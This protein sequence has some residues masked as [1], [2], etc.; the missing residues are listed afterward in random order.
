MG[1][2]RSHIHFFDPVM[3]RRIF[4]EEVMFEEL[5]ETHRGIVSF[6]GSLF[7]R[8]CNLPVVSLSR[9]SEPLP[10]ESLEQRRARIRTTVAAMFAQPHP[11]D[12]RFRLW[13]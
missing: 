11:E 7:D 2:C 9:R 3:A 1:H 8:R 5:A 10:G 6:L 4:L 12:F 13:G